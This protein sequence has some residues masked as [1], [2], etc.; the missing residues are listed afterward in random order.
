M[1]ETEQWKGPRWSSTESYQQCM[2][3]SN[4]YSPMPW[5]VIHFLFC[6]EPQG[7][8]KPIHFRGWLA[9]L[10]LGTKTNSQFAIGSKQLPA[11]IHNPQHTRQTP[12]VVDHEITVCLRKWLGVWTLLI[13]TQHDQQLQHSII[14]SM[15]KIAHV[16]NSRR[17]NGRAHGLW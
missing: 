8:R 6:P 9:T 16:Y 2:I 12:V 17:K 5:F 13:K 10:L 15:A 1:A 11:Q 7:L 4:T 3:I 14:I